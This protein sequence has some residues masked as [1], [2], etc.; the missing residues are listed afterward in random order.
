MAK[1]V[2]PLHEWRWQVAVYLYLAGMGAG[3]FIIGSMIVW[4]G[5][6]LLVPRTWTLWKHSIDLSRLAVFWGPLLVAVGAPFLVL[7]LGKKLKFYTACLNPRTS[8]LARGFLIL[9]TFILIGLLILGIS[10]LGGTARTPLRTVLEIVGVIF[11]F[12]T[13]VYTG[14]LLKSIQYVPVWN[15]PL[16]PLLFLT[17]ALSTG[18][19]CVLLSL[20]GFE[21]IGLNELVIETLVSTEQVFLLIEA[22]VL[23]V[24]LYSG[25]RQ[26]D[27]GET[28]VRLLLS[29]P[30]KS[31]FWLGIVA[32]GFAFPIVLDF[33]YARFRQPG[34]LVL[35]GLFL[36]CGGFFLRL[37]VIASG[38]RE[39]LP[40]HKL[41]EMKIRLSTVK[42]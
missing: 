35:S 16:L 18:T 9:S 42:S 3:S 30:L 21:V 7:D 13:A 15:T 27:Q 23:G 19:M 8:W 38:V 39:Q 10:C 22:F 24:Y 41:I 12:V 36:L 34:I 28:S 37:G 2:Q 31:L 20:I 4:F 33:I 11:A 17:S 25:Y 40:M 14:V 1:H 5:S 29:G 6:H 26:G 32:M